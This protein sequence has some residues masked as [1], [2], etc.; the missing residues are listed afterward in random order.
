MNIISTMIVYFSMFYSVFMSTL[1]AV[2]CCCVL[3]EIVWETLNLH[4]LTVFV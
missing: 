1:H 3:A 2:L 4:N